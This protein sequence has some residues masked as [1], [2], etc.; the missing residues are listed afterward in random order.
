MFHIF[1]FQKVKYR[2]TTRIAGFI[3][4]A[5]KEGKWSEWEMR[6]FYTARL[7]LSVLK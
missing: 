7:F 4:A 6:F 3:F 1:Q 2:R 5:D